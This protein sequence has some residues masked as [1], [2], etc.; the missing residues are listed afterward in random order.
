PEARAASTPTSANARRAAI[1]IA[2]RI[3]DIARAAG[4]SKASFYGY[5]ESKEALFSSLVHEFF[6]VVQRSADERHAEN[7]ALAARLGT[8]DAADWAQRTPRYWAFAELEHRFTLRF[9]ELLW[10]WRDLV[11]ALLEHAS[12]T[13]RAWIDGM[14]STTL[15]TLAERLAQAMQSGFLRRDLD[16]EIAS[17]VLVGAYLQLGRRMFR[18]PE[19]PDLERW[20]RTVETVLNEGLR[21]RDEGE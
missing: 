3:E 9:L 12:D 19:P 20:A 2:A 21:P 16:P 7:E 8:C 13:H 14:V 15:G 1:T 10:E 4:L 17:E 18:L 6:S 11:Q 5:F